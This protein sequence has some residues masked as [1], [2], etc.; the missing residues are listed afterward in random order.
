MDPQKLYNDLKINPETFKA[1]FNGK[2]NQDNFRNTAESLAQDLSTYDNSRMAGRL[3]IYDCARLCDNIETYA[4]TLKNRLSK[5]TF[6]YILENKEILQKVLN[7]YVF[8]DYKDHDYFSAKTLIEGYLLKPSFDEDAFETP[9]LKN[10]RMAIQF[11]M[12]IS[13]E[14][15]I[16]CFKELSMG[17]YTPASPTIFNAG[18]SKPQQ[19]S[20]F[21]IKID[22]T[23]E[24]ILYTGIGDAGLI[25]SLSGGLGITISKIRHSQIG[26]EGQS[27]GVI[28]AA[29][30]YDKLITYVD[31]RGKRKGAAT[32]FLDI[33]HIDIW[34]FV[35]ATNNFISHELRFSNLNTCIW[36]HDLFFKRLLTNG[37]WTV[38]CP[39][40]AKGLIG[41]Y[42]YK[43]EE[44]YL[45]Y[46]KLADEQQK[47][48]ENLKNQMK[49]LKERLFNDKTLNSQYQ[50]I[51]QKVLDCKKN[52]IEHKV[53]DA[54]ELFKHII[55]IQVKSGMP[56]IMYGDTINHKSNQKNTGEVDGSNLCLEVTEVATPEE[57]ASCN[58]S[59]INMSKFTKGEIVVKN[60]A[61]IEEI[62]KSIVENYDFDLL[63]QIV[64]S[65][66]ENLDRVISTNYYPLDEHDKEYNT[67][68]Q[69]KISKLNNKMRPL[70]VGVSGFD[71]AIKEMD[72][73]YESSYTRR[74][75]KLFFNC[76]YFNAMIK[77]MI[78]AI[79]Y[80]KYD[81]FSTK[82]YDK[83]D[84]VVDG[85]IKYVECKGSPL[86][87]GQFQFDLWLEEFDMLEK[88]GDLDKNV[89]EIDN[90]RPIDPKI[91]GQKSISFNLNG[92]NITI[93]PSWDSLRKNIMKYGV[94]NSL[95]FALMPTATTAQIMRN[96]ESTE[97][98]VTNLYCRNVKSG[99]Y[100]I[101]NR[102][103]VK[104]LE[105]LN[106]W[107]PRLIDFI[108]ACN[109]SV[110]HLTKFIEDHSS[111]YPHL[112]NNGILNPE[113][114]NRLE[115]LQNKYK[116]MFEI[117]QKTVLLY[118]SERG[119][120]I[121]QSQSTNIYMQDPTIEKM[122]A[123]HSLTNKLRLK[124]GMYYL[125]QSA[126]KEI[127]KFNISTETISYYEKNFGQFKNLYKDKYDEYKLPIPLENDKIKCN[128][129]VCLSCQ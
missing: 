44:K 6:K 50:D 94:R 30:V 4:Y 112:F 83:F 29:R 62:D 120:F 104:D 111:I 102:H 13:L 92:E 16:Q 23:L 75:N 126:A 110:K 7:E 28:P 12:D 51:L 123:C 47:E 61:T 97:C 26:V 118:A 105:K 65:V 115:Y 8:Y 2:Y 116:T 113:K 101:C 106:I 57:I 54:K 98:H 25:S 117:K 64:C 63:G 18:T 109:G 121:C 124:T 69:G 88:M 86:S 91:W 93:E 17:Y 38:F 80:G 73:I 95:I 125:R 9:S 68:S 1:L 60:D 5:K 84:G 10:M 59:S 128:D 46:E 48:Y 90:Y 45:H 107:N 43:F 74:F 127:G 96:C 129:E 119:P 40:K 24:S 36:M 71:D 81:E 41:S 22:D 114:R 108:S 67:V 56:Y 32:V 70:G 27:S 89:I 122:E 33:S 15:V 99:S 55:D 35:N 52:L 87:N 100:T 53:Y 103:L 79:I 11:Y 34:D 85:K 31:Q 37:K 76:C 21:L 58:L 49:I 78:L 20:C 72:L 77:S 39:A 42:G 3:L 19:S 66:V 82:S 14:K